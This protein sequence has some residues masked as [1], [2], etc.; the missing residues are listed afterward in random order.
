MD[1]PAHWH[2][3]PHRQARIGSVSPGDEPISAVGHSTIC[4]LA[5]GATAAVWRSIGL[6]DPAAAA[7]A[8]LAWTAQRL[9]GREGR[10]TLCR[11]ELGERVNEGD[12]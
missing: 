4:L 8:A 9:A 3:E 12:H 10:V 5:P 2:G 1:Y 11:A 6:T 7:A